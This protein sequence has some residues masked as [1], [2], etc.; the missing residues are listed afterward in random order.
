MAL[1]DFLGSTSEIKIIDFLV[2]NLD[3][4]YNQTEIS[5]CLNISRTTVNKKI[6]ELIYNNIVEIKESVGNTK[7]Y[8]L[9]K[10]SFVSSL[11][12]AIYDHSFRIAEYE[13]EEEEIISDISRE[14]FV[15][16]PE[17]CECECGEITLF[18]SDNIK[19]GYQQSWE[20]NTNFSE[21]QISP[22]LMMKE[23][24]TCVSA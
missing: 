13:K 1:E 24:E 20:L 2:E 7:K 19:R 4:V 6:P 17:Y 21:P 16:V 11:I 9:K 23:R 18:D 5:E 10:N 8:G 14:C 15:A 12:A 3:M 22:W